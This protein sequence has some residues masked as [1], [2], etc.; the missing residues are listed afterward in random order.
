MKLK[1]KANRVG[2]ISLA[3]LGV[4]IID[5][6]NNSGIEE[7]THSIQ[8][9]HLFEVN[10]RYQAS[11]TPNDKLQK[12][13][14]LK[15]L[16]KTRNMFFSNIYDY[17]EGQTKSPLQEVKIAA[18]KVFVVL[19]KYGR[20]L[21]RA[22]VADLTIRYI[23]II[24]LLQKPEMTDALTKISLTD[25][26]SEFEDLQLSYESLYMGLGN[27]STVHAAP[28]TLRKEMLDAVKSYAEELKWLS[29]NHNTDNWRT[30]YTNVE[31]RFNEMTVTQSRKKDAPVMTMKT[32][33]PQISNTAV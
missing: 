10:G 17:V 20:N 3:T 7:A 8:F 6:V 15:H 26:V 28:S 33:E 12:S 11:I 25:K 16:F 21:S 29:N 5:T 32:S 4:R 18:E 27:E 9:L 14:E 31:Q 24:D 22:R 23:R 13:T 30:L 19:N 1:S 2:N